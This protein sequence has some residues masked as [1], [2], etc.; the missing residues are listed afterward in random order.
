[1]IRPSQDD[2]RREILTLFTAQGTSDDDRMERKLL[3]TARHFTVAELACDDELFTG[4][5]SQEHAS[6]IGETKMKFQCLPT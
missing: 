6:I 3:H 2:L 5:R 1:V 4:G